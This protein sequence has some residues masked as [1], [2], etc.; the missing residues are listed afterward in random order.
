V[1]RGIHALS[2]MY[3][4]R[5]HGTLPRPPASLRHRIERFLSYAAPVR[6]DLLLAILVLLLALACAYQYW[7]LP[8]GMPG[9]FPGYGS[10]FALWDWM[11]LSGLATLTVGVQIARGVRSRLDQS[12]GRLVDRGVLAFDLDARR[13]FD[14]ALDA[15]ARLLAQR[16]G[17]IVAV[18]IGAAF[19]LAFGFQLILVP[20]RLLLML[21]EIAL[22]FVAGRYLG[23]MVA[24]G[25]LGWLLRARHVQM[26]VRPGHIDGAAG[27]KPIGDYYLYQAALAA[28]P[29]VFLAVWLFLIPVWPSQRY[30]QWREAYL[31]LLPLALAFE[32]LAF[33]LPMSA[34][35]QEMARQKQEQ[36]RTADV[37]SREIA[38]IQ[39]E[40]AT[41]EDEQRRTGL[42]DQ[43][44]SKT[45]QYWDIES[46]PTWP[47]DLRMWRRFTFSNL[48]LAAPLISEYLG[49]GGFA[50]QLVETLQ[51]V[52]ERAAA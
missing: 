26:A 24:F 51:H 41:C 25:S 4:P 39:A 47:V 38:D 13:D 12:I 46:M 8:E 7:G 48:A 11:L 15:R 6:H 22:G 37:R 35:H 34:F 50:K 21:L 45:Q 17:L 19:V 10:S 1:L 16:S 27:L 2:S 52:F 32:V 29:A 40:L 18:A 42:K 20:E 3:A 9:A 30:D 43:L 33:L 14:V 28:L 44:A 49:L 5:R 23:R 36:R 31:G